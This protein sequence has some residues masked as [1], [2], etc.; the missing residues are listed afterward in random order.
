MAKRIDRTGET[1][2]NLK[3][4][5]QK[6]ENKVNYSFC[7]CALCG[8]KKWIKTCNVVSGIVKSCGCSRREANTRIGEIHGGLL[9][10]GIIREGGN[11]K[12]IC[13]CL[14]C[15]KERKYNLQWLIKNNPSSCGCEEVSDIRGIRFGFLEPLKPT[16]KRENGS[17]I[18]ECK[19]YNCGKICYISNAAMTQRGKQSC[20]CYA[21]IKRSENGKNIFEKAIG[22]GVIDGT[23]VLNL[24][25]SK[26]YKTSKTGIRGVTPDKDCYVA[27]I[28]FKGKTY[29]LGRFMYLEDA[30][31]ARKKAEENIYGDFLKWYKKEFPQQWE[32]IN[33]NADKR[34]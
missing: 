3:I 1:F 32:R 25:N 6:I 7:E 16:D 5:E 20:G 27:K 33:K 4:L 10:R 9:I 22:I 13:E 28:T 34:I 26:P 11:T 2:G 23:N 24:I 31:K 30:A 19:C 14:K 29:N 21:H 12:A 18:W 17:V 8:K 15:K